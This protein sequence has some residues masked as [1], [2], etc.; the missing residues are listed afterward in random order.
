MFTNNYIAY[1]HNKFFNTYKSSASMNGVYGKDYKSVYGS[2]V[3]AYNQAAIDLD[4]G[5][6]M[7]YIKFSEM[8]TATSS[9]G[10]CGV[11]IGSGSTPATREDYKLESQITSGISAL[12]TYSVPV[13]AV[14]ENGVCTVSTSFALK[15]TTEEDITIREIGV[16]AWVNTSSGSAYA[17]ILLERTVL[18]QPITIKPGL[19]KVLTYKI[20]FNQPSQ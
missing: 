11:L 16:Y 1:R 18:D 8:P 7:A 12:N 15:N 9:S 13:I 17:H 10:S 2:T 3:T 19:A 20:T 5:Y 4:I 14:D 6:A